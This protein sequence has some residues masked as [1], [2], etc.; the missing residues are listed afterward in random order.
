MNPPRNKPTIII[1]ILLICSCVFLL[2]FAA[3]Y[4][5]S[6]K[7]QKLQS[8]SAS[9]ETIS[10]INLADS[11][12][13][14]KILKDH[15]ENGNYIIKYPETNSELLNSAVTE[16][17]Q[18]A[19]IDFIQSNSSISTLLIDYKFTKYKNLYSFVLSQKVKEGTTFSDKKKITFLID[20]KTN[21]LVSPT[22]VI[23]STKNII[24]LIEKEFS[25]E[26]SVKKF[27]NQRKNK[28]QI[29]K[30]TVFFNNFTLSKKNI[31]FYFN[32]ESFTLPYNDT[33]SIHI[34]LTSIHDFL[35]KDYQ[36]VLQKK[37][38][39][40]KKA[41]ALT[42]D[43]GP[44]ADSSKEILD[45]LKKEHIKA[46]FFIL[47][48]QAKENPKIVKQIYK[49]GHELGNHS[50]TH[51]NLANL[52]PKKIKKEL[53]LTNKYIK[54]ASGKNPTVFRPPY[55]SYDQRVIKLSK[56]PMILWS[57]DT[58]DWKNHSTSSILKNIEAEK[59]QY[60]T[61]LMH[62]IHQTS[63]DSLPKV[64]AKL[65]RENYT[66]VTSSEMLEI[67]KALKNKK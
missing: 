8:A 9:T 16:F 5:I 59:S 36:P 52:S 24:P 50:F 4:I 47:G 11:F 7:N 34:S 42:F 38:T 41:V 49:D 28:L 3:G 64:I 48:E 25:Q 35:Q 51:A 58:L 57:V 30:N 19:K 66:F 61:L 60:M 46:T 63:A 33:V 65:K 37:N 29:E 10:T 12:V 18:S 31:T 44:N 17:I 54:K 53:T 67:Q 23:L 21:N 39:L 62:D 40:P 14:T 1:N 20:S 22:E 13:N 43:D 26:K 45:I 56:V 55:G 2:I 15:T 6:F 32:P 27:N